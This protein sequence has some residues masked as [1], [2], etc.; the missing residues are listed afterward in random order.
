MVAQPFVPAIGDEIVVFDA[1]AADAG[2]VEAGFEGYDE[3]IG[4]RSAATFRTGGDGE[5]A[6]DDDGLSRVGDADVVD[7]PIDIQFGHAC[8]DIGARPGVAG[9]GGF[10]AAPEQSDFVGVLPAAQV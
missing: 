4:G 1:D 5:V 6:V 9:V 2:N 10:H 8:L 7:A 3:G